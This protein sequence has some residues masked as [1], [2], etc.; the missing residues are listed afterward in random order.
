MKLELNQEQIQKWRDDKGDETRLLNFDFN[1]GSKILEL[2]GYN[3]TWIRKMINKYDPFVYLIEP[4]PAFY[5]KI[6]TEFGSN[7]KFKSLK[8]GIAE[9]EY[10]GLI[11]LDN[12][13]TSM[14]TK[15]ES[16]AT[17]KFQTMESILDDFGIEGQI[18]LLQINIEG[19]EY[20]ILE[21]MIERGTINRFNRIQVQ[22]HMGIENFEERRYKIQYDLVNN[23]FVNSFEYPY[24]WEGWVK[25]SN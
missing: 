6:Y 5:E 11:Y 18:D 3:G 16:Q 9:E 8:V 23:G 14:H 10:E 7:P 4:V 21:T 22:F 12:D 17:V 25:K 15:G 19:E 24:V 20:R 1:E 2:G 13:S